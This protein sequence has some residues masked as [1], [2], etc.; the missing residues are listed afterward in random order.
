MFGRS[1]KKPPQRQDST[2]DQLSDLRKA[3]IDQGMDPGDLPAMI[4][5]ANR[6]GMY[7]AADLLLRLFEGTGH[8]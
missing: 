3:A 7:D 1:L 5:M 8:R 2:A 4:S 6:Q